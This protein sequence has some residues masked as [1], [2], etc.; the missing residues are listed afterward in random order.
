MTEGRRPRPIELGD[1]VG[2]LARRRWYLLGVTAL[3]LAG[4]LAYTILAPPRYTGTASVLVYPPVST[5]EVALA[6]TPDME[7]EQALAGSIA[8]AQA[9]VRRGFAAD[10]SDLLRRLTVTVPADTQILEFAFVAETADEAK[11]GAQAF[12]EAYLDRRQRQLEARNAVLFERFSGQIET[13]QGSLGEAEELIARTE[14]DARLERLQRRADTLGEQIAAL[15]ARRNDVAAG[16][17]VSV[18]RIEGPA[19][20]PS[21]PSNRRI[22]P[23]S[24]LAVAVGLVV[25][26]A[27]ALIRDRLDDRPR[28]EEELEASSGARALASV[29]RIDDPGP[30]PFLVDEPR[31]PV[32]LADAYRVLRAGVTFAL[33]RGGW[34]TILVTSPG[35]GDGKTTV[36]ANLAV[37]IARSGR[38][39]LLIASDLR[40]QRLDALFATDAG[41]GFTSALRA[42][43]SLQAAASPTPTPNLSIV[44]A[45][46][47]APDDLDLIRPDV[48][49][50][51]L[52]QVPD[53][54]VAVLDGP[55]LLGV[56]DTLVFAQVADAVL[57][58]IDAQRTTRRGIERAKRQLALVEA[59]VIGEVLN[60]MSPPKEDYYSRPYAAPIAPTRELDGG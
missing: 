60:K 39:V 43:T 25:G 56:P 14:N 23:V 31:I 41:A 20:V 45:G 46:D 30:G 58:V 50:R 55:P 27:T 8:V 3:V 26:T 37:S 12:A 42:E 19:T 54:A 22:V 2:I 38:D 44:P 24:I 21:Q 59:H 15:Q 17:V 36:A 34:H 52:E 53:G 18:G 40:R 35:P 4:A 29:P 11:R 5:G 47:V 48:V 33:D 32:T 49:R 6:E 13:L 16:S 7:T 57:L 10:P 9:V 28:S 51:V 1:Y